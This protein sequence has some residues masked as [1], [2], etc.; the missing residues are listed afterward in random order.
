MIALSHPQPVKRVKQSAL[1]WDCLILLSRLTAQSIKIPDTSRNTNAT[2][3]E[4]S[5]SYLVKKIRRLTNVA[6]AKRAVAKA[7]SKIARVRP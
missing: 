7:H 1:I 6:F 2:S 3:N 5:V 4:N